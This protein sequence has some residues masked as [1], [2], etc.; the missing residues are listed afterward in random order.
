MSDAIVR[1]NDSTTADELTTKEA[2]SASETF[3]LPKRNWNLIIDSYNES[4]TK[5]FP[6]TAL[7][8]KTLI[9][10]ATRGLP[11][12][13]LFQV[14]GFSVQRYTSLVTKFND[15]E[16]RL[17]ELQSLPALTDEEYE[18]FQSIMRSPFRLLMADID[19]AVGIAS[20]AD[21][22][23]FNEMAFKGNDL[24]AMKMRALYK[25]FAGEKDTAQAGVNVQINLGGDWIKDI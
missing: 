12:R 20:L 19:R 24:I 5:K 9:E 13:Y 6:L 16:T 22:E 25:E 17:V 2:L 11:P 8:C 21:W 23:R 7:Q 15:L 14:I 4:A 1:H 18:E 3:E 10:H